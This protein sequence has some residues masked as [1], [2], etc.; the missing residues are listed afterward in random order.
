M[1]PAR[2]KAELL[3]EV[4]SLR[5]Q[6]AQHEATVADRR[7]AGETLRA[8]A[9]ELD[10]TNR[11]LQDLVNRDQL[12]G[13]LNRRGLEQ[14]L[15]TELNRTR[16]GGAHPIA[17]M[18]DCDEF[19]QINDRFGHTVGD[20]VLV[21]ICRRIQSALRT[22]DHVA[23]VGG[24]EFLLILPET[25]F[26]EGLRIAERVR[27]QVGVP[28]PV[29]G[30]DPVRVT[31]SVGVCMIPDLASSVEEVVE[32]TQSALRRSK[33]SG[34]DR[35]SAQA[36]GLTSDVDT[37]EL[38]DVLSVE[39]TYHPLRQPIVRL[40]DDRVIGYELLTRTRIQGLELPGDFLRV[41]M[42]N[43]I[44]TLADLL[45]LK[46]C[47]AAVSAVDEPSV[48][49]HVNL[50][51]STILN[52]STKRLL[53]SLGHVQTPERLCV[54]VTEQQFFGDSK[55]LRQRLADLR[56][57]GIKIAL[58]DVG[59][60]RTSLELLILLAPDVVKI[61]RRFVRG[62]ANDTGQAKAFGRLVEVIQTI[63]ARAIAE[64]IETP[65]DRRTVQSLGV[66]YGQ[67]HL[68]GTRTSGGGTSG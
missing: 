40:A 25:G 33:V 13:A 49:Y 17:M 58:D 46:V 12:T 3:R 9:A 57:T 41:A 55:S 5:E 60:G 50:F 2:T 52:T 45:C 63:G 68:W 61:D 43:N 37:Q 34:K 64:G 28:L 15:D 18:L 53:T 30:P 59:F 65:E 14:A 67:G 6:V 39:E 29:G 62:V 42:A 26:W 23:R 22:S 56:E 8:V 48:D 35:V 66:E 51:P 4:E 7:R 10:A 21:E 11:R 36:G 27:L 1:N 20:D 54:E 24:D 44:L 19:K 38:V 31:A 32:L 16:R 47:L